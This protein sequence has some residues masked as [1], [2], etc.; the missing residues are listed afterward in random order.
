[1]EA[2]MR[3]VLAVDG[4]LTWSGFKVATGAKAATGNEALRRRDAIKQDHTFEAMA[5]SRPP[6]A[7]SAFSKC[8]GRAQD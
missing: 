6:V 3:G 5:R 8:A 4:T 2:R 1:V 7:A